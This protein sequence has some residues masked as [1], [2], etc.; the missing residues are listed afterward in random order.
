MKKVSGALI[1]GIIIVSLFAVGYFFGLFSVFQTSN[2]FFY[3]L[4]GDPTYRGSTQF[5]D[6]WIGEYDLNIGKNFKLLGY[7]IYIDTSDRYYYLDGCKDASYDTNNYILLDE[8]TDEYGCVVKKI[9]LKS[10]T[11]CISDYESGC[12][13]WY[14][15]YDNEKYAPNVNEKVFMTS[16]NVA[17]DVYTYGCCHAEYLS[18]EINQVGGANWKLG[19]GCGYEYEIYKDGN[20]LDYDGLS[21]SNY[22]TLHQPKTWE[23]DD[24][25]LS[26][27]EQ[28]KYSS[29]TCWWLDFNGYVKIPEDAFD[30]IVTSTKKEYYKGENA[31]IE[32]NFKNNWM[33]LKGIMTTEFE[34][35]TVVGSA[36]SQDVRNVDLKLGDNILTYEIPTQ[37][38]TD[39]LYA[40]PKLKIIMLASLFSNVNVRDDKCQLSDGSF[41]NEGHLVPVESC[42]GIYIG[43]YIGDKYEISIY[44]GDVKPEQ[45]LTGVWLK[46]NNLWDSFWAWIL[47]GLSWI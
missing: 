18:S 45:Q 41:K 3:G 14:C 20:L 33:P 13:V 21:I 30:V 15:R 22:Y 36:K 1:F 7:D 25:T 38:T 40:T 11:Y 39:K 35:P 19:T 46:I 43:D 5:G 9:Q 28:S 47:G 23:N 27:D 2:V 17:S 4:V 6:S 8:W 32:I 34:V 10:G 29:Y 42:S 26:F 44:S 31:T 24:I 37:Q 12:G 16:D